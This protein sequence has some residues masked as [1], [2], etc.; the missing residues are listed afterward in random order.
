MAVRRTS[1]DE[2]TQLGTQRKVV[3]V[4]RLRRFLDERCGPGLPGQRRQTVV[5]CHGCFDIVHP[6]HIRY[7]Q[8]ARAQG[9]ILIVSITGDASIDKGE[10]RP[11]IP[12]ELRAENLAALEIVDYVVID[13]NP[14]ARELL[15]AVKPDV[16][17]KGQEYASSSDPRFLAEREVVETHGGRVIFSS[18]QVVFSSSRIVEALSQSPDLDT[19]RL[20]AICRRHDIHRRSLTA[21]I[22][23]MQEQRVLVVGDSAVERYVL[24]DS[25][26]IAHDAPMMSLTELDTE[27]YLGGAAQVALQAAALGADVT[28]VT[29]LGEDALSTWAVQMLASLRVRVERVSHRDIALRT[30]FLVDDRKLLGICR[31]DSTPLDTLAERQTMGRVRELLGNSTVVIVHDGGGGL[32]T[33]GLL[34][35]LATRPDPHRVLLTGMAGHAQGNL[36]GLRNLDLLCCSER[37]LRAVFGPEATG[38]LSA[39]SYKLMQLTQARRMLVMLGKRGL[40]TFDRRSQDRRSAGWH[41]RLQSEY[42][43]SLA[44][45]I[46]DSLGVGEAMLTAASLTLATGGNLMQAAYLS[47]AAGAVQVSMV[48]PVPVTSDELA[49]WATSR[50]ELFESPHVRTVQAAPPFKDQHHEVTAM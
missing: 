7:L 39:L 5:Q 26:E 11:Y 4:D 23:R 49:Q 48:G 40:V 16:Y 27:D 22:Q 10:L 41:D 37:R 33:P 21:L 31:S 3:G 30:R 46:I 1:T 15:E 17:V 47:A 19:Q 45:R 2:G 38:G 44:E 28:L 14:T 34:E 24:C 35:L 12:E 13:P 36:G 9:D 20:A 6:G 50:R 29:G 8:F 18:G 43:T 32:L 25:N 42:L